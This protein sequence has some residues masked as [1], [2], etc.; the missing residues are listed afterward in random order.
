MGIQISNV[1]MTFILLTVVIS[2]ILF[3]LLWNRSR[4]VVA[5]SWALIL[6]LLWPSLVNSVLIKKVWGYKLS[7][8]NH[9]IKRRACYAAYDLFQTFMQLYTGIVTA[10]SRFFMA[11]IITLFTLPRLD[12]SPVPAWL[13]RYLL[14]DTGSKAYQATILQWHMHNHPVFRTAAWILLRDSV[15][16]RLRLP[17]ATDTQPERGDTGDV[18]VGPNERP[19]STAVGAIQPP[20]Q[21]AAPNKYRVSLRWQMAVLLLRNPQLRQWRCHL[22]REQVQQRDRDREAG[23]LQK[24]KDWRAQGPRRVGSGKHAVAPVVG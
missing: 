13:E 22:T 7:T 11:I 6:N 23:L 15:A 21:R 3:P 18:D 19:E 12:R 17:I 8:G 16:R 5:D 1:M 10:I 2:I 14:L 20:T 24:A 9:H 4:D